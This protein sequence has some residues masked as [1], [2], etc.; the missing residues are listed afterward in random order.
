MKREIMCL[1]C[2]DKSK[3]YKLQS[4]VGEH[5]KFVRGNIKTDNYICDYC[6]K[7]LNKNEE[8]E[9]ISMWTDHCGIAYYEW[10]EKYI[11]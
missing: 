6:G 10:E 11:N 2:A 4:F 1:K 9:A 8:V 3:T 7:Q 5:V